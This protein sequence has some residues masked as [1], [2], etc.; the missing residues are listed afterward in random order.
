VFLNHVVVG[1][2]G[3]DENQFVLFEVSR[4]GFALLAGEE[5]RAALLERGH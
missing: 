3:E 5:F 4:F 1:E 2:V